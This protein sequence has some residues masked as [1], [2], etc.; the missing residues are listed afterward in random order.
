MAHRRTISEHFGVRYLAQEYLSGALMVS[1]HLPLL[2][3][4]RGP[5]VLPNPDPLQ[6]K[7]NAARLN[8]PVELFILGVRSI[9]RRSHRKQHDVA[10]C[11]LLEGQGDWNAATLT[12]QIR[13]HTKNCGTQ[14]GQGD[15][16]ISAET[17]FPCQF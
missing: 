6:T 8:T 10:S 17:T 14:Q 5:F 16:V 11:G 12:C 3:A 1:W 13:F 2:L 9:V 15:A 4:H 7:L